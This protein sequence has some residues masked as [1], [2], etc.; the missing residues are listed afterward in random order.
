MLNYFGMLYGLPRAVRRRKADELTEFF[1]LRSHRRVPF[2]HLSTGLKQRLALA[3]SLLNDPKV[4][5]LDEPTVGLDPQARH[6]IWQRLKSLKEQGV[7]MMLTS[8]YMD[9]VAR[10]SDR[11]LVMD[12]GQ[13]VAQGEPKQMVS[14]LVGLDVFE[15]VCS[16]EECLL[17]EVVAAECDARTERTPDGLYVYTSKDCAELDRAIRPCAQWL[18]RPA[19]LEDLFIQLTGRTLHES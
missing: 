10:L 9:E 15:V 4:L 14:D 18:R 16:D 17:L 13:V 2:N 1:E 12:Q 11:I 7:T 5:F 3:K 6:L 19:N 8:H